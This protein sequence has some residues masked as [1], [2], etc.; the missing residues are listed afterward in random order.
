MTTMGRLKAALSVNY[1]QRAVLKCLIA[2]KRPS[3]ASRSS[4]GVTRG[5]HAWTPKTVQ[6][7][8]VTFSNNT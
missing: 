1:D 3:N 6:P 5:W 4:P 8:G 7:I 2:R